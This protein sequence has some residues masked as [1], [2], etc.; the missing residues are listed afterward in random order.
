MPE[1]NLQDRQRAE[2]KLL[3][4]VAEWKDAD[5]KKY[6]VQSS[7]PADWSTHYTN[8]Y[9]YNSETETYSP[10]EGASAPTWASGTYYTRMSREILGT[11]TPDSSIEFN[12]DSETSTDIRGITYADVNKT[13]P[14]QS[15]DP[16][17]ILGGSPLGA[18]LSKAA[19]KNDISAYN[20]VFDVYIITA[21]MGA[22]SSYY[23]V[24]HEGCS[25]FPTAIGGESYVNMPIEVHYSNKITEGTVN[26]LTDDFVFT[27][28]VNI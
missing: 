5:G 17:T 26:V 1:I 19:L 7:E 8:Y 4:H 16:Y 6:L 12:I 15:F 18:Y 21:Y 24:K 14:T 9:T 27:P 10:V 28:T 20:G 25:I 22:E 23:A 2:R 13:E 3:I 11:R